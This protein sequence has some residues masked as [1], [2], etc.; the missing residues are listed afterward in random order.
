MPQL[1]EETRTYYINGK[2]FHPVFLTD[3]TI[4]FLMEEL[5]WSGI[6]LE[7]ASS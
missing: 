5:E 6:T 4:K 3:T 2:Y 7:S 1:G